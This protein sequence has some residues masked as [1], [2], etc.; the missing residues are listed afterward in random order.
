[1]SS[2]KE[3]RNEIKDDETV[4]RFLRIYETAQTSVSIPT[5]Q[6]EVATLHA[7][8]KSRSLTTA[9]ITPAK[10]QD[11][12][13]VDMYT[14]SRLIEI[15]VLVHRTSELISSALSAVK[16]HVLVNFSEEVRDL[17]STKGERDQVVDRLFQGAVKLRE[18]MSSLSDEIDM[19]IKDI[20]QAS[21]SLRNTTELLRMVLDR[22]DSEF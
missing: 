13:L 2:I 22:K 11:A 21:F 20:D 6:R 4:V 1:M 15:K 7:S 12:I 8:R 14:R 17:A 16:K 5:V 3:L 18:E 9:K 10:L 19:I